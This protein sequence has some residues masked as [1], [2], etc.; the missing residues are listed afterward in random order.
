MQAWTSARRLLV[1]PSWHLAWK[2]QVRHGIL[3]MSPVQKF[4]PHAAWHCDPALQAQ[5]AS[6]LCWL[7]QHCAHSTLFVVRPHDCVGTEE[8]GPASGTVTGRGVCT[9]SVGDVSLVTEDWS[10]GFCDS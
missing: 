9:G 5:P 7:T 10:F 6:G 4:V 8:V 2:R 1:S 3:G